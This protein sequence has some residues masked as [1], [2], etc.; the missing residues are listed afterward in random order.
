MIQI[1]A[2]IGGA[3]ERLV[4][5]GI[6]PALAGMH[7]DLLIPQIT[8][9]LGAQSDAAIASRLEHDNKLPAARA[10]RSYFTQSSV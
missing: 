1:L 4:S 9:L 2:E 3:R 5:L 6:T 7:C 10:G 8:M